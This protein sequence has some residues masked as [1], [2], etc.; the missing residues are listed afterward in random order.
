MKPPFRIDVSPPALALGAA[1]YFVLACNGRFWSELVASRAGL[2]ISTIA[3]LAGTLAVLTAGHYLLLAAVSFRY[4]L[5]P[6]LTLVFVLNAVVVYFGARFDVTVDP[7]M[8]RNVFQTDARET[9]E[10][11]T[12]VLAL[13][14]VAY[15]VLPAAAVWFVRFGPPRG[16]AGVRQRLLFVAGA[17]GV[18]AAGGFLWFGE[19]ASFFRDNHR[20]R[21][22]ITPA[23]YVVSSVRVMLD[24]GRAIGPRTPVGEDAVLGP[25]WAS[26]TRPALF[27]LVV[28]ETARA[29]NFSLNGYA[30]DTNPELRARR[31]VNFP[32]VE[33][34]GTS[35]AD[36]LPCM[37]S[38]FARRD[39]DDAKGLGHESLL[40]VVRRAGF[41]VVWLDNNSGCKGI[42][43]GVES[44][45]L[46]SLPDPRLCP[47]GECRDEILLDKAQEIAAQTPGNLLLVLHQK[48]SH[49]PA[50]FRRYPPAFERFTPPCRSASF[51]DCTVDEIRNAYDNTIL[52]TDHV[53][54]R[55]ID[56]LGAGGGPGGSAGGGT[57]AGAV[58]GAGAGAGTGAAATHDTALLYVSD[59]GESLGENGLFLHGLPFSIAP[60]TQTRVP[61]VAWISPGFAA[62]FGIDRA[63]LERTAAEPASHD[64]LFHSVLGVLDIRTAVY[65]R[66]LDLFAG[67]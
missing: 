64:N 5:K 31:V 48:G 1:A 22:L 7:S 54:G 37:F 67:R 40:D 36:A 18:L 2:S 41:R 8:M 58:A 47:D 32:Q 12:P 52:Y 3:F 29:Q 56:W 27:V 53:L 28:G 66:E 50:Y 33:A 21:Y 42:C 43:Q 9:A 49:G 19:Y 30:R 55:L 6:L 35:T 15:A 45:Q 4:V 57:G 23:N 20:A 10:L 17:A 44:L 25:S 26:R 46:D 61:M 62:S 13:Y 34:C 63:A 24:N 16:W 11:L 59:H 14:L 51:S 39:Y 60:E 65:E 38:R